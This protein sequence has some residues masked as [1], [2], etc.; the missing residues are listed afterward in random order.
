MEGQ[1]C[2]LLRVTQTRKKQVKCDLRG[3]KRYCSQIFKIHTQR[4][5]ALLCYRRPQFTCC[6]YGRTAPKP[7]KRWRAQA[8]QPKGNFH[9][10]PPRPLFPQGPQVRGRTV[11][12]GPYPSA[13]RFRCL[14]LSFLLFFF[15]SSSSFYLCTWNSFIQCPVFLQKALSTVIQS[16]VCSILGYWQPQCYRKQHEVG[17]SFLKLVLA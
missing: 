6:V 16:H 17:L 15:L 8:Q 1:E 10:S 5:V 12:L 14:L 4:G 11:R 13:M 3:Q 2:Q 9:C 7:T